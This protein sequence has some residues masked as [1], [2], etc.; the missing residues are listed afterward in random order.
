[1]GSGGIARGRVGTCPSNFKW[2][3]RHPLIDQSNKPLNSLIE[4]STIGVGLL[5]NGTSLVR[6]STRRLS[7]EM[8]QSYQQIY[9]SSQYDLVPDSQVEGYTIRYGGET[10]SKGQRMRLK[11]CDTSELQ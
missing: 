7:A 4:Q 3:H 8:L 5:P 2:V 6:G 10:I 11:C 1:M 9:G